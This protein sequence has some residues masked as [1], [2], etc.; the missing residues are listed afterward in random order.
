MSSCVASKVSGFRWDR[1]L[2]AVEDR[3][4]VKDRERL[5]RLPRPL[6]LKNPGKGEEEGK[7]LMTMPAAIIVITIKNTCSATHRGFEEGQG[8]TD[9][10]S[11]CHGSN[12]AA[13]ESRSPGLESILFQILAV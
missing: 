1:I 7:E 8:F 12:A 2:T 6:N 10:L 3:L 11:N 5:E 9:T 4:R 13:L